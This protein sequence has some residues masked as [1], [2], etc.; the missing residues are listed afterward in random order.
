MSKVLIETALLVTLILIPP[1]S[2]AQG[3]AQGFVPE[4]V[5]AGHSVG[6]GEMRLLVGKKRPFCVESLGTIQADGSLRL[7][8]SVRFKGEPVKSRYWVMR[9][10]SPGHY[11]G[12]LSDATGPVMART[13][14]SQLI[15]RY[16]LKPWGLVMHQTLDLA[17]DGRTIDNFSRIRFLGIPLGRLRET[18]QLTHKHVLCQTASL[19]ELE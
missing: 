18:I 7:D 3:V 8:Q 15:L 10:I 5:F 1:T 6:V 17:N 4:K 9:Q 12:T 19:K 14:G 2:A 13:E 16:K 11:S